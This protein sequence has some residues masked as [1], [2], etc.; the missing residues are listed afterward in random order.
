MCRREAAAL[1]VLCGVI[2]LF[3]P[4][5]VQSRWLISMLPP[6]VAEVSFSFFFLLIE[7]QAC[8][9][10]SLGILSF[11]RPTR[12]DTQGAA[13][14]GKGFYSIDLPCG[15]RPAAAGSGDLRSQW[16]PQNSGC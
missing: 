4:P 2:S 13:A 3:L 16:S 12:A 14:S 11:L 15:P 5:P 1:A 10:Q 6:A 7:P 9:E 8:F